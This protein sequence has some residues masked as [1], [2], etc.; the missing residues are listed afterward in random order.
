MY[1]VLYQVNLKDSNTLEEK[2]IDVCAITKLTRGM[3][4]ALKPSYRLSYLTLK[5][6]QYERS[7]SVDRDPLVEILKQDI[8]N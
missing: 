8:Q 6:S 4:L 2:V 3:I 7:L 1:N 5:I